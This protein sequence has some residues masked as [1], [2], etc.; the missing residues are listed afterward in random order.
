MSAKKEQPPDEQSWEQSPESKFLVAL[1]SIML[2]VAA[3]YISGGLAVNETAVTQKVTDAGYL[4]VT[5]HPAQPNFFFGSPCRSIDAARRTVVAHTNAGD[6]VTIVACG[7]LFTSLA[8]R[9]P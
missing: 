6:E 2:V 9:Q 1:V 5:V 4:D 7:R 3:W 8:I